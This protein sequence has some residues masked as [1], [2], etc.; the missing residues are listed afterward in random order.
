M[1]GFPEGY[2]H[3]YFLLFARYVGFATMG[4][5]ALKAIAKFIGLIDEKV[6]SFYKKKGWM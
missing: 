1:H 6:F 2:L 4:W 5:F 3:C